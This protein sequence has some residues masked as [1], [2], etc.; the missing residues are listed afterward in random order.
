VFDDLGRMLK[1]VGAYVG[2]ETLYAYDANGNAISVTDP[3]SNVTGSTFDAL[4]RLVQVTDALVN[5]ASYSYDAAGNRET[6]T[7]Q[8]GLVTS[9]VHNGFGEVIRQSSPDTGV[10]DFEYDAAGRRTRRTDARGVVT[11]WSYDDLGRTLTMTF[12]ASP[13]ENVTY[14]YDDATPG[15]YGIGRLAGVTD[16]SGS[17]SYRYDADGHTVWVQSVIGAQTY[18]TEYA[19]D[20]ANRLE[21]MTYPSGRIVEYTHDSLS[22]IASVSTRASVGAPLVTLASGLT[23]EA[24][25]GLDGLTYGN[26]VTLANGFDLDGRLVALDAFDGVTPVLDLDYTFDL[27]GNITG[28][29]DASGGSRGRDF[30][31]DELHRLTQGKELAPGGAPVTLQTDYSYDAVGNRLTRDVGGALETLAYDA[32]SNRLDSV[33]AGAV[34]WDATYRPFGEMTASGL[35]SNEQ[36]FPGQYAD[37]ETGYYDNWH[38]TYDPALGRYLQSDPIGLAG[39]WNTYGYVLGNPVMFIDP[40][41]LA[42]GDFPPA[43][44]GYDPFK[45]ITGQWPNNGKYYVID[46]NTRTVWTVHPEDQGHWRHWDKQGPGGGDDGTW[47]PNSGKPWPGQKK[48]LKPRQCATDPSGDAPPWEPDMIIPMDPYT[49]PASP[50]SNPLLNPYATPFPLLEGGPMSKPVNPSITRVPLRVPLLVPVP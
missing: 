45:W 43:P 34:V 10:T 29:A 14:S 11:E 32:F 44:P 41:G 39:G 48:K 28:I 30:A 2:E 23:Y 33:T 50:L 49:S 8:R 20:A 46:P 3:L 21:S 5:T 26:G 27:A 12:P 13:A 25:G 19:Y 31:Y 24:F 9:Y 40:T 37:A 16:D 22:R 1:S 38:R 4:N 35:P 7:D 6:A 36:R 15:H 18:V 42:I 17:T 47:P